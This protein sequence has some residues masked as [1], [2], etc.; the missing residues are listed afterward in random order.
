MRWQIFPRVRPLW[1]RF[2][3]R[4]GMHSRTAAAVLKDVSVAWEGQCRTIRTCKAP[5]KTLQRCLDNLRQLQLGAESDRTECRCRELEDWLGYKPKEGAG[6]HK[7]ESM[8]EAMGR[9]PT[10]SRCRAVAE[11]WGVTGDGKVSIQK[12]RWA[13]QRK[14]PFLPWQTRSAGFAAWRARQKGQEDQEANGCGRSSMR[15]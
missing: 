8:E 10:G 9:A 1:L 12:S 4:A 3:G 5:Q 7:W 14:K 2:A 15:S 11:K 13:R 6:G